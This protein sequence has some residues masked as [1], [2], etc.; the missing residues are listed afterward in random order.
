MLPSLQSI[1]RAG[2]VAVIGLIAL[3]AVAHLT[4]MNKTLV[5]ERAERD[6]R[7]DTMQ[8]TWLRHL[9]REPV[10]APA[11]VMPCP[12]ATVRQGGE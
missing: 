11:A 10:A 6:A 2:P 3:I 12:L 1:K 4:A 7:I 9:D 5:A 8:D